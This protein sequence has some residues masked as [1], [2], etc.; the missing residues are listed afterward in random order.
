MS[1]FV[2]GVHA[3]E[4]LLKNNKRTVLNIIENPKILDKI[5]RNIAHQNISVETEPLIGQLDQTKH[6]ILLDQLQDIRNIGAIIRSAAAFN[7]NNVMFSTGRNCPNLFERENYGVLAKAACGGLEYVNLISVDNVN[8]TLL[9]LKKMNYWIIGLGEKENMD[10]KQLKEFDKVCL[11]IG[12]E[13]KGLRELTKKT[14]DAI[15]TIPTNKQFGC[16]NASVAAS[17][18]MMALTKS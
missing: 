15:C 11:I 18:G 4:H 8:H 9:K 17:I 13:G 3:T 7:V 10:I 1:V 16:L 5:H 2:Y 6:I 12:Q 14:C